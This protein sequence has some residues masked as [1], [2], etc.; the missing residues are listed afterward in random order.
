MKS[1]KNYLQQSNN[2]VTIFTVIKPGFLDKSQ[3]IIE[4]FNSYGWE[5]EKIRTVKL[6]LSQAKKLY[7]VHKNEDFYDDLCSYMSSDICS[8]IIYKKD[9]DGGFT[10][11]DAFKEVQKIKDSIRDKWGINDCK[12]VL[13]SSDSFSAMEQESSIFF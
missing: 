11:N 9:T 3:N 5:I 1:L 2:Q 10:Q 13:H 4:I 6:T 12:N 8:A 7:A